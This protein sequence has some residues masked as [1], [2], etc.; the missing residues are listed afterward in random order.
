[1]AYTNTQW[2]KAKAY[3]ESG[4]SL[5]QIKEKTGIARNTISQRAKREQW[6][7]GKN[8]GYIEAKENFIEQ[9][10]TVLEQSGAVALQIADEIADDNIRRKCLVFNTTEKLLKKIDYAIDN[11]K[12]LEKVNRGDGIQD[13]IPVEY[14]AS[15]YKNFAEA[16]D[17][18]SVTLG[19]NQRHANSQVNINNTNAQQTNIKTLDDFYEEL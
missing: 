2:E 12:P 6:E 13:L 19:V 3:Y 8:V 17:K 18:A 16:I 4:L 11:H 1:M 9:K 10:G 5:S 14:G 15:D 7:Q